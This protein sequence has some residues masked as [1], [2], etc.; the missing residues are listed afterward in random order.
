[1]PDTE[2][3]A[4]NSEL[5]VWKTERKGLCKTVLRW[6]GGSKNVHP[7]KLVDSYFLR[8][9]CMPS[10]VLNAGVMGMQKILEKEK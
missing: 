5:M 4:A 6:D 7:V 9:F 8:S 1:M 10:A 2:S 3:V